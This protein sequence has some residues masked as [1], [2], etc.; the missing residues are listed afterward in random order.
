MNEPN[1]IRELVR[2]LNRYRDEYY[3]KNAPSVSDEVYDR[4]YDELKALESST[5]IIL[6]NSPTQTVGYKAVSSLA[7]VKH[8]IPLLSLDKTKSAEELYKFCHLRDTLLMLKFDGLTVKLE[9]EDGKLIRASTRGDGDIG[10]DVTHN[11]ATFKNVPTTIPY[12]GKLVITGEAVVKK[13]DFEHMKQTML[14]STGKQYKNARNFAA[15][16]VRLHDANECAKRNLHYMP[17]NV[18]EGL[19]DVVGNPNLRSDKLIAL[20]DYGFDVI[21]FCGTDYC[22]NA[23]DLLSCI[24]DLQIDT[25]EYD[26]PTD[27]MVA[28]YDDY[29]YSDSLGRTGH[30]Y[31]CGLAYKFEDD[32]YETVLREIEWNTSRSGEIF[33]VSIF[34]TVEIDGC[35]VSRASLHNVSFIK[36]LRL[37]VGD[38]ILV[39]KRN[40]IIPHVE[41]NL[42]YDE[43]TVCEIPSVCP[44][45][46]K[47]TRLERGE[48]LHCDN[49]DCTSQLLK[50]FVHFAEKKAM[51]IEGLSE[52]ILAKFFD[53]GWLSEYADIYHLDEHRDEIIAMDGFG[54]KS[55]ERLWSAIEAS[56]DTDFVHFLTALDIPQIG[57]TASRALGRYFRDDLDAFESAVDS[58]FDFTVLEDFG[59]TLNNNIHAWFAKD[60]NRKTLIKMKKEVTIMMNTTQ[61]TANPFDGK[62]VVVTGTLEN[63]TRDS[64]NS[65]LISLGATAYSSVSKKTDYVLAGEKAGSKLT[66]AQALGI[67][68]LSE[69]EFLAM[70]GAE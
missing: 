41:A 58:G 20:R 23:D 43:S 52:S 32:R 56:R 18:L 39:T 21:S 27:G 30:H 63:F 31:N 59:E 36:N 44:N 5:G 40:M 68:V 4:L 33:P 7:K 50:K 70:I 29:A 65:K 35:D 28:I 13:K 67:P 47:P 17:F 9:Y 26:L 62:T 51:N 48:S 69:S 60:E 57:N 64:I 54:E 45:C 38:R 25:D 14:D 1:R 6:A 34:D 24:L 12:R 10:E 42:D 2:R 11:L 49:P 8:P 46:G 19:D 16:S 53:K 55:Y 66:K 3:N 22:Q 15:G 61:T 37:K